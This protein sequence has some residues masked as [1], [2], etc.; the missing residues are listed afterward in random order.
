MRYKCGYKYQ[1]VD[2][3]EYMLPAYFPARSFEI[4]LDYLYLGRNGLL[5]L[6]SGYCSDGPSGPT[7]DTKNFMRGAFIHDA[8]Y[9]FMRLGHLDREAYRPLADRVLYDVIREDGM[10]WPRAKA[11][12]YAVRWGGSKAADPG[13]EQVP[14]T[15][16]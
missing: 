6:E 14:V 9:Q 3:L 11:V 4:D 10:W 5:I 8:L 13:S 12:Y 15:A 7:I 2:P 16:P 1:L